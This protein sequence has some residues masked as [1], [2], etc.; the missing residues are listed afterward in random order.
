MLFEFNRRGECKLGVRILTEYDGNGYGGE[1][2]ERTMKFAMYE[3]G[4]KKVKS[5]CYK[6]NHASVKMHE[7]LMKRVGED[8]EKYYYERVI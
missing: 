8:E 3:L 6:E 2:F 4:I 7:K 1:A 5:S